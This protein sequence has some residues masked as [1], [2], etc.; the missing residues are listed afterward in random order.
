[1]PKKQRLEVVSFDDADESAF[2]IQTKQQQ[3][4]LKKLFM[5]TTEAQ[6][7]LENQEFEALMERI[8]EL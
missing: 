8:D 1:M 4:F 3:K 7:T 2:Q 5:E 6:K